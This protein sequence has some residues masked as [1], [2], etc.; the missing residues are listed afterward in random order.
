MEGFAHQKCK[1]CS[2]PLPLGSLK[3]VVSIKVFADFDE[4]ISEDG[5]PTSEDGLKKL[6]DTIDEADPRKLEEDVYMERVF[7]LCNQCKKRFSKGFLEAG[8]DKGVTENL[9]H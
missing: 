4:V 8:T 5:A 3:Y 1:M 6:V 7:V 2:K 9:L